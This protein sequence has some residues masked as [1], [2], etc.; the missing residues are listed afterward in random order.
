MKDSKKYVLVI[1]SCMFIFLLFHLS[2]WLI[3]TSKIFGLDK[4]YY[5]GDLARISYTFDILKTRQLQYTLKKKHL[6]KDNYLGQHIDLLTLGDS[7]SNGIANGQNPYYQDFLATK[8]NVNVLN[9]SMDDNLNFLNTIIGLYNNGTLAKIQPKAILIETIQREV[10]RLNL[11]SINFNYTITPVGIK[12]LVAPRLKTSPIPNLFPINEINY[13]VPFYSF[14]SSMKKHKIHNAYK[15][16]LKEK[17]FNN[18]KKNKLI[19]YKN[20]IENIPQ[21]TQGNILL[22][23]KNLNK[24]AKILN[25][26]NIILIYMPAADKYDL[27][28][29]YIKN[30]IYPKSN[31]FK[32]LRSLNK[33][34]IFI[35]TQKILRRQLQNNVSDIFYE[36]DTH[37]SYKASDAVTNAQVFKDIFSGRLNAL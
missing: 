32:I 22:L 34:Y 18:N 30:K 27:Y 36:D 28:Y 33:N 8:Y 17:L 29:P 1:I 19:V 16:Y 7:F 35:D 26:S 31:F 20:D 37:W 6:A 15:F 5:S 11:N 2:I 14:Y 3:F 4:D 24:L 25:K 9:I 10:I 13:K 23:N 21:F 12:H